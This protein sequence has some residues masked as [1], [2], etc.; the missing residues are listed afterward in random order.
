[1]KKFSFSLM[2]FP[3]IVVVTLGLLAGCSD[4]KETSDATQATDSAQSPSAAPAADPKVTHDAEKVDDK[5]RQSQAPKAE[6]ASPDQ[7]KNENNKADPKFAQVTAHL[8][9]Q[10]KA[11]W[12]WQTLASI[13]DVQKWQQKL[14]Y[15]GASYYMAASFDDDNQFSAYGTK[16]QPKVIVLS[17][18]QAYSESETSDNVSDIGDFF[19]PNELTRVK[20]NCDADMGGRFIQQ[21]YKW[22]KKGSQPLYVVE[23]EEYGASGSS[24]MAHRFGIAKSF[25]DFFDPDYNDAL[26]NLQNPNDDEAACTFDL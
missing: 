11:S 15:D 21:F 13:P 23:H 4:K 20:S 1:M 12:D 24:G 8:A 5:L 19:S 2:F 26:P 9:L 6:D 14:I 10:P 3:F 17:S 25:D 18:E 7:A 22:Q 16:S